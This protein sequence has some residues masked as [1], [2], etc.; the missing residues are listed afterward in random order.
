MLT[1]RGFWR[2]TATECARGQIESNN[3]ELMTINSE[4]FNI[5]QRAKTKKKPSNWLLVIKNLHD[6]LP[7]KYKPHD[8]FVSIAKTTSL[9]LSFYIYSKNRNHGPRQAKNVWTCNVPACRRSI[10]IWQRWPIAG[11]TVA[12]RSTWIWPF[13]ITDPC[14]RNIRTHWLI[15]WKYRIVSCPTKCITRTNALPHSKW[16]ARQFIVMLCNSNG[17]KIPISPATKKSFSR[18]VFDAEL[19]SLDQSKC[20]MQTDIHRMFLAVGGRGEV[21]IDL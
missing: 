17:W 4:F 13:A 3:L 9:I 10:A 21:F 5:I 16:S 12:S 2:V 14:Y 1:A 6:F 19:C 20:Y 7:P 15:A 11:S 18:F 8:I